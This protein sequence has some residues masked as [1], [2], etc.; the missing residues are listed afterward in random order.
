MGYVWN[1]GRIRARTGGPPF[2]TLSLFQTPR[3]TRLFCDVYNP[4]SKTYCKRLQVLCPE[5]SRDPKVRFSLS[6]SHF[7]PPP[8]L[9][10]PHSSLPPSPHLSFTFSS[11]LPCCFT[12]HSSLFHASSPFPEPSILSLL[13]P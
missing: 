11:H 12:L 5:H 1:W 4:Q 13:P 3:A 9:A 10:V 7:A 6:S 8:C 2:T